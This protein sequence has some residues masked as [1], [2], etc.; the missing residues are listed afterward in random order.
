LPGRARPRRVA[1]NED[2]APGSHADAR[3]ATEEVP[4]PVEVDDQ[5]E[6][7]EALFRYAA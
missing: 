6:Q 5:R 1:L 4:G 3:P 7:M 2:Q